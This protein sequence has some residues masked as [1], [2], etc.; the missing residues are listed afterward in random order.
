MDK[1]GVVYFTDDYTQIPA[2][3]RDRVKTEE[4][5]EPQRVET[6]APALG[7]PQKT[8]EARAVD[9][10]GRGEYY[11]KGRVMPWK[12]QLKEATE[13]YE[14]TNRRMNERIEDQS[15]KFLTATQS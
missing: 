1:D 13:N 7:S 6:P 2:Q 15:G 12:K 14:S 10:H 3:Y 11:W 8:E 4:R 9:S 5:V